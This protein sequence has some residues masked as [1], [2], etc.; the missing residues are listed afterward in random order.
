MNTMTS[1]I[2]FDDMN[3][4]LE[5]LRQTQRP[6]SY[7]A[8]VMMETGMRVPEVLRLNPASID[9]ETGQITVYSPRTKATRMVQVCQ[10]LAQALQTYLTQYPPVKPAAFKFYLNRVAAQHGFPHVKLLHHIRHLR[11]LGQPF[12]HADTKPADPAGGAFPESTCL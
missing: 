11:L 9:G 8:Q 6:S 3:K 1:E 2:P 12:K 5:R 7:C 10:E 4:I